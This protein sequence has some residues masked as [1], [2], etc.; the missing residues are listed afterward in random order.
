[1]PT[2]AISG[3]ESRRSRRSNI[4]GLDIQLLNLYNQIVSLVIWMSSQVITAKAIILDEL[5]FRA[6]SHPQL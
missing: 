2:F 5:G 4:R 1:M 3:F 6:R